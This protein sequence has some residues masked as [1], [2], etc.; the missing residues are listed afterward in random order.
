LRLARL[1]LMMRIAS[2]SPDLLIVYATMSTHPNGGPNYLT[3]SLC[4]SK[5]SSMSDWKG[6]TF[7]EKNDP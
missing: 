5:K 2:S 7:S 1:A 6:T 3:D 4:R